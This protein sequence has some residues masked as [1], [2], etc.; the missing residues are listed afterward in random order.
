M[1]ATTD[2]TEDD[3]RVLRHMLGID[4][5]RKLP[6]PYRDHYCAN[7]GDKKLLRLEA[8]GMVRL[9]RRPDPM[10]PYVTYSTTEAGR[11]AAMVSATK[12]LVSKKKRVY[13]R[14]LDVRDARPDLSF[15]E[16]L[17]SPDFADVRRDA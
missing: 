3:L 2:L 1:E 11:A 8:L 4:D 17:T 10:T 9:V 6:K 15:R 12:R 7:A 13:L 14:F 16:F 5:A